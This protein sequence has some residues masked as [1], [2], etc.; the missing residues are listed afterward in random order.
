LFNNV[1]AEEI[2]YTNCDDEICRVPEGRGVYDYLR[3]FFV[4]SY[5]TQKIYVLFVTSHNTKTSWGA[6]TEVG[7]SWITQI[8]HKIFN[9]H[10]FRPE[11]PLNDEMQ[12]QSTNRENATDG[13]LWMIKLNADIFCQKIEAVCDEL[14]YKKKVRQVNMAHLGTLIDIQE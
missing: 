1:P 12:W 7:A 5:S 4:D 10:P 6:I 2:L 8:D 13:E 14:G 9:I 11:H 3:E